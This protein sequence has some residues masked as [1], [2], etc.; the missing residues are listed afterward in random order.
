M[1]NKLRKIEEEIIV[2]QKIVCN[3]FN[4][5]YLASPFDKLI[6]IAL[7]TF[8]GNFPMPIN[9]LKHPIESVQS[10]NWYIWAGENYSGA[11]DFFKPMHISHLVELCP[12]VLQYL[13]L[14]PGWRFLYDNNQ[15][16]DVWYDEQLLNI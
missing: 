16:E 3:R 7:D 5:A 2:R 12:Q 1:D 13:G 11:G 6:G 10:A 9:G 8:E 4:T 14:P 15:Y